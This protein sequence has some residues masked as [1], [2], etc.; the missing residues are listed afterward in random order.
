M[1]HLLSAS[2]TK[3]KYFP[4]LCLKYIFLIFY[5]KAFVI[6]FLKTESYE[7]HASLRFAV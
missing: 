5:L 3:Y 6:F 4:T 1:Y 7:A 2:I